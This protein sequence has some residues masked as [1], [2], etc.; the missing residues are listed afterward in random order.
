MWYSC[1]GSLGNLG[2]YF[3]EGVGISLWMLL[4]WYFFSLPFLLNEEV[5][6]G[7]LLFCILLAVVILWRLMKRPLL[8]FIIIL[9]GPG[10]FPWTTNAFWK[11]SVKWR[12]WRSINA[13]DSFGNR[14]IVRKMF[15]AWN[16]L[17]WH[18]I[19]L[20]VEQQ[21]LCLLLNYCISWR[22]CPT[23]W[24]S[25]LSNGDILSD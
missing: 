18:I 11:F 12:D 24:I 7:V 1:T 8:K 22:I 2:T 10:C 16:K 15:I 9:G 14:N 5:F 23:I 17:T 20:H 4:S 19:D 25:S 13:Q 3:M 6:F 21:F